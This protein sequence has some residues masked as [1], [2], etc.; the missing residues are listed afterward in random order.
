[1]FLEKL[2]VVYLMDI[3]L[4]GSSIGQGR[5]RLVSKFFQVCRRSTDIRTLVIGGC[6]EPPKLDHGI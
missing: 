1:M 6:G 2:Q 5:E 3:F 4:L